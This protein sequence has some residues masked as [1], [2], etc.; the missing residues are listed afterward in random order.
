MACALGIDALTR[1]QAVAIVEHTSVGAPP[2]VA[3]G[4]GI[5]VGLAAACAIVGFGLTIVVNRAS[6]TYVISSPDDDV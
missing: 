5:Y 2:P 1:S 3:V 4:A 6:Q